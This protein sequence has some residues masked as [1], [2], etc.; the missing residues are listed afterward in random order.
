[1]GPG[2]STVQV[3]LIKLAAAPVPL[4]DAFN[5]IVHCSVGKISKE[6]GQ[7]RSRNARTLL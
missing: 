2:R 4:M 6:A 3:E 1:M 7:F 5:I